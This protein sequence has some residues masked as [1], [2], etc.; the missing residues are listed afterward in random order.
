MP[1]LSIFTPVYNAEK[2]LEQCLNSILDQTFTDF[3]L[4]IHDDGS[5]DMSYSICERYAYE[6][7]RIHLTKGSNGS[8]IEMMNLFITDAKG[9]YLGFVDNDDY[10]DQDFFSKMMKQ[11]MANEA[12][13]VISSYTLVDSNNNILPWYT[14]TLTEGMILS[15]KDARRKFLTSLD[16]EGFRW[17]KIY[18]KYVFTDNNIYFENRFPADIPSEYKLL[19]CVDKVVFTDSKGYYYRQ[20]AGSEVA[21]V[22]AA[23]L[24]GFLNVFMSVGNQA[25]ESGLSKEGNYYKTWRIV[26]SLY[27]AYKG[28]KRYGIQEWR[29]V[30]K[31]NTLNMWIDKSLFKILK[32]VLQY[33]NEKESNLKFLIKTIIVWL[34]F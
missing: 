6:D 4:F 31:N 5:T 25:I 21:T 14:P 28:R 22:N 33:P 7:E 34:T 13:C 18:K 2:Y 8:S 11:I 30:E 16:I 26:N 12:D 20:S 10:L 1:I 27:N 23:K 32:T 17:N 15:G 19:S 24:R 9:T 3:E 29:K